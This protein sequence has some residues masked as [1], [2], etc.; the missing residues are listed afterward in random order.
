MLFHGT[1]HKF[2][3]FDLSSGNPMNH[4]GI[5]VY[6]TDSLWDCE[7]HYTDSSGPDLKNRIE[8]L[9]DSL[10]DNDPSLG[11]FEA[12][13]QAKKALVGPARRVL[14]CEIKPEAKLLTLG[15]HYVEM[16]NYGTMPDDELELTKFA[17]NLH[18][19][20]AGC[21]YSSSDIISDGEMT[22]AEI[23]KALSKLLCDNDVWYGEI[24][25][26][27]VIAA[28]YDGIEYEDASQWFK[29][30]EHY[31]KHF[32]VYKPELVSIIS[33]EELDE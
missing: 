2:E 32:V 5:G 12:H 8:N 11:W 25:K 22:T 24:F 6:L 10:L 31:T 18:D 15:K 4:V 14:T 20:L 16:Y 21:G 3:K 9:A 28:G 13:T 30:V 17:A 7:K 33:V 19:I 26:E 23:L 1:T 29:M 27:V